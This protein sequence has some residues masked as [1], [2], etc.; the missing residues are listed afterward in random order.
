MENTLKLGH[1]IKQAREKA[2]LTQDGL[3]DKAG[4]AYSTLA[5]IE[6]GAIK[7]PSFDTVYSITKA[8][9]VGIE[10]LLKEN[11]TP[12]QSAK[13]KSKVKFIF[14]DVNGVMVRF[15]HHAFVSLADETGCQLD[16]VESTFWHYN[17][18]ANRG[19]MTLDEFN[20]AMAAH[21]GVKGVDWR[22]HYMKAIEPIREMQELLKEL[23]KSYKIGLLTNIMPKFLD[24]MFEKGI[25]SKLDFACV[26]D[27]SL[28]GAVKPEDKMYKE[29]EKQSGFKGQ[30]I[31]FI[32][33]SRSNLEAAEKFNWRVF[34]FDDYDT[35]E[36]IKGIR[37]SLEK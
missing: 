26:V 19:Q 32:D 3:S 21:L 4:L 22:L 6:Q 34:W 10:E 17:E 18:L 27:S 36:S 14:C 33:D 35:E 13:S 37:R 16:K 28:I 25:L 20:K 1:A 23:S 29:A 12:S 2:G 8:L 5:K 11:D 24:E 31:F 30:E 15:Y 7:N 9:G